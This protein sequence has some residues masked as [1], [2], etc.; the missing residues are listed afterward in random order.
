MLL[1][2]LGEQLMNL[3]VM[4]VGLPL[5]LIHPYLAPDQTNRVLGGASLVAWLRAPPLE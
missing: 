5:W 4:L 3:R 1:T 2:Q